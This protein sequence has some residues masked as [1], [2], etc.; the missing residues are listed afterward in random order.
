V[1]KPRYVSAS[2]LPGLRGGQ[3]AAVKIA[4]IAASG[5][6]GK[7]VTLTYRGR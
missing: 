1:T 6:E 3:R 4:A 5:A 7:V 2:T